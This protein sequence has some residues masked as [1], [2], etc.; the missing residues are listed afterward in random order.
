M[1]DE[2]LLKEWLKSKTDTPNGDVLAELN[3]PGQAAKKIYRRVGGLEILQYLL[4]SGQIKT[5]LAATGDGPDAVKL[6]KDRPE[7]SIDFAVE[8]NRSMFSGIVD[9]DD[10]MRVETLAE[11][12]GIVKPGERVHA[13]DLHKAGHDVHANPL[14]GGD[15]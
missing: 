3:G 11:E 9:P 8:A 12:L 13:L 2:F 14:E 15:K 5:V 7:L 10:F 6:L 1:A 4:D